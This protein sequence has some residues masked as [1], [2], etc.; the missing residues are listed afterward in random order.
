MS[1]AAI[2]EAD[3]RRIYTFLN[4][5]PRKCLGWKEVSLRP[6]GSD[7]ALPARPA[8][9]IPAA[10]CHNALAFTRGNDFPARQRQCCTGLAAGGRDIL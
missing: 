7:A 9:E 2:G 3:L 6:C 4:G 5:C 10:L 8:L 1:F